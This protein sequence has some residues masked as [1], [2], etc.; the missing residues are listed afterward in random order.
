MAIQIRHDEAGGDDVDPDAER[1]R[2]ARLVCADLV[3]LGEGAVIEAARFLESAQVSSLERAARQVLSR[4]GPPQGGAARL[5]EAPRTI[6]ATGL[7]GF[8][9]A[10][11]ALRLRLPCRPLSGLIPL[12]EPQLAPAVCVA[13]LLA[14]E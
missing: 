7:G 1:A 6:V 8:L 14:G 11:L 4:S 5:D 10:D 9:A 12:P 13:L 3:T 2:L